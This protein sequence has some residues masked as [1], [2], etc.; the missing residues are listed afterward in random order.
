MMNYINKIFINLLVLTLFVGCSIIPTQKVEDTDTQKVLVF[1][2]LLKQGWEIEVVKGKVV[3]I[4]HTSE[5]LLIQDV[6]EVLKETENQL[7]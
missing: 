5:G 1:Q 7:W 6:F 3:L 2:D 4:K